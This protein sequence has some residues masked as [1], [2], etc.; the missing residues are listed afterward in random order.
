[1]THNQM[2]LFLEIL[3]V[4]HFTATKTVDTLSQQYFHLW[5]RVKNIC[6]SCELQS[7]HEPVFLCRTKHPQKQD[8]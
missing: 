2:N 8:L 7:L 4:I 1:M 5:P 6:G 3:N